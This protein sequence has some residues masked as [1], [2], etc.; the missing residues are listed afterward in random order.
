M[1]MYRL[2]GCVPLY[3]KAHAAGVCRVTFPVCSDF[4]EAW[5]NLVISELS[6]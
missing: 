6:R 2:V 5:I 1:R 3:S 4:T